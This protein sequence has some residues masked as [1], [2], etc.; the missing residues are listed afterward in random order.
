MIKQFEI[1]LQ[2]NSRGFH[3]ITQEITAHLDSLP[4]QG[5][6]NLFIKHTSAGITINE[7]ADSTVREDFEAIFNK[8]IP[9]NEP[10]YKH[11]F[12]GPDDMPAHVK[13]SLV[14]TSLQIPITDGKLNMGTWQGIYLC[15]F[16][17][18]GGPRKIVVTVIGEN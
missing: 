18:H 2:S 5:L 12:E 11:T 6:L 4:S 13:A 3:L 17:N 8:L 16:R 1:T 15:E 14:G 7:N 9:E 10:F